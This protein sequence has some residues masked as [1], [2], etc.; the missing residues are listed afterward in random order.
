MSDQTFS[1]DALYTAIEDHIRGAIPG[2]EAVCFPPGL[3][4]SIP[5][6]MVLLELAELEPGLDQGT[7]EA[8]V[9][10]HFEARAIVGA[11]QVDCYHQAAFI[12]SRLAVLLRVQHWGQEVGPAEFVRAAQDFTRPELDGYVVWVVEWTQE[13]YLGD[14]AWPWPN[15]PPG[16]LLLGFSPNIGNGQQGQYIAPEEIS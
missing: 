5:V 7:G 1:L 6:P 13:L 15:Q 4:T 8:A 2:L 11:E 9:V 10:A 16:S 12:A 3:V 14:E